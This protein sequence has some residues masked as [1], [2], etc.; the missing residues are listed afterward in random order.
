[1]TSPWCHHRLIDPMIGQEGQRF[2]THYGFKEGLPN[3]RRLDHGVD[4]R[5]Q[6]STPTPALPQF[7][8]GCRKRVQPIAL[9]L[10]RIGG[11]EH[12]VVRHSRIQLAPVDGHAAHIELAQ[13][14]QHL[15]PIGLIFAQAGQHDRMTG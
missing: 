15:P 4:Q 1:M 5:S 2:H 6:A 13:A 8:G 9:P 3:Q 11:Q 7:R 14:G 10:E 12:F